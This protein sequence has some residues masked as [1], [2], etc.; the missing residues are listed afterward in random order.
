MALCAKSLAVQPSM[1]VVYAARHCALDNSMRGA[2]L[3]SWTADAVLRMARPA[4]AARNDVCILLNRCSQCYRKF[5]SWFVVIFDW[6]SSGIQVAA[7]RHCTRGVQQACMPWSA[8]Q[9]LRRRMFERMGDV[10]DVCRET[11]DVCGVKFRNALPA[12]AHVY[13]MCLSVCCALP[14]TTSS[15]LPTHFRREVRAAFSAVI[16]QFSN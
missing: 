2:K 13:S 1:L 10:I 6:E 3:A 11:S 9:M 8:G 15:S 14:L 12:D 4:T 7:R 16:S 5:S